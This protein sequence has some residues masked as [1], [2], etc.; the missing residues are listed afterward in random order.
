[1]KSSYKP[2]S[3]SFIVNLRLI[4]KNRYFSNADA[5]VATFSEAANNFVYFLQK[6]FILYRNPLHTY[7]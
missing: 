7:M 3:V 2:V 6:S 5:K 1:L 4:C